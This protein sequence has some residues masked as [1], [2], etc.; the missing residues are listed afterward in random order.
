MYAIL[1]AAGKAGFSTSSRLRAAGVPVRAILRDESKRNRL[2][3]IGCEVA[4]ADLNDASALAQAL[5]GVHAVQIILPPPIQAQDAAGEM[6]R[7]IESLAQ[8]LE[9]GGAA[10]VLAIS[11]Y[12]AHIRE[13]IGMP[14]AYRLFEE[15]LRL[16]SMNKVILR[17]AEHMEGWAA[18]LPV[19]TASGVLPSLH[20]PVARMFPTISAPELGRLSA[21]LLL[22]AEEW[23]GERIL[24]AEGPR[25]YSAADVAAALGELLG[26]PIAAQAL[27]REQWRESLGRVVSPSACQL[28]IDLY[29]A[30]NRGGLVDVEPHGTVIHGTT[31][32]IDALR[33]LTS[34]AD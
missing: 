8:A 4:L 24:H 29:D 26:R 15:R 28:L 6:R 7:S 27:P 21:E 11:D 22:R 18:F 5:S 1:G 30:Q 19:A 33:P 20:H 23:T 10:R 32:V 3:A 13:W 16:L 34:A 2:E 12:G 31:M 14:S 17:S 9:R 25:R